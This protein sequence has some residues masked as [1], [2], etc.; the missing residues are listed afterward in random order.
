[1]NGVKKKRET[2]KKI[3]VEKPGS[4]RENRRWKKLENDL[5]KKLLA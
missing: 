5:K 2:S 1:V 3:D 4:L